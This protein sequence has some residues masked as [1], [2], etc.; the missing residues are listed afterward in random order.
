LRRGPTA[1]VERA[2]LQAIRL[3]PGYASAYYVLARYYTKVGDDER[4]RQTLAKFKDVQA[5]DVPSRYGLRR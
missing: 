1:D 3:D 2:L 5:N 4:A